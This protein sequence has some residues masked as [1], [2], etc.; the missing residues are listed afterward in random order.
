VMLQHVVHQ[1]LDVVA[2]LGRE[3]APALG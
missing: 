2:T 1:D 3:I